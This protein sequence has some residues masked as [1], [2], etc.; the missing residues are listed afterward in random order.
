MAVDK[1]KKA[2]KELEDNKKS[3][4]IFVGVIA[5]LVMLGVI[6]HLNSD[7][8]HQSVES[9]FEQRKTPEEYHQYKKEEE[10]SK[11]KAERNIFLQD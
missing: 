4:I 3:L 2:E 11:K 5:V 6:F 10:S 7:Q 9:Y 8:S 1:E